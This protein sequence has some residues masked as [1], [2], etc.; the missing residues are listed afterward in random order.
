MAYAGLAGCY[1]NLWFFNYLPPEQSLPQMKEATLRSLALNDKIAESHVSS[2][3]MKFWYEWNFTEAEQEFNKAIELNPNHAEA[4]EQYGIML[5]ILG[6]KN[7]ALAQ[8]EMAIALDPFSHM[9]NWGM[10]WINWIGKEYNRSCEQGKRLIEFEPVFFGGHFMLGISLLFMARYNDALVELKI[11]TEQNYG[12]F[13]L[14]HLGLVLGIMGDRGKTKEVLDELLS[15][16]KSQPVGNLDLAMVYAS[17]GENDIAIQY[18]EKGIEKHEG[19][20]VLLK[21]YIQIIPGF[22][23]DPRLDILLKRIGIN[24]LIKCDFFNQYS[25]KSNL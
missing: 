24:T 3:R 14:F 17:L 12:S 7:E 25:N 8:G 23:N 13:T 1:L 20:M 9:I 10:G 2:A 4:H 11:A 15:I 19:V 18:L 6:K 22:S 16:N 5:G 21:H